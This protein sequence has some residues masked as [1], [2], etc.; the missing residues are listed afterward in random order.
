MKKILAFAILGALCLTLCGCLD[1]YTTKKN[2]SSLSNTSS[3][4]SKTE[5]TE[6]LK[7]EIEDL[8]EDNEECLMKIYS[9]LP[10]DYEYEDIDGYHLVNDDDYKTFED[11]KKFTESVYVND[12]AEELL[13]K[14]DYEGNP[15]YK[16]IGG[17]LYVNVKGFGGRGYNVDW[18]DAEIEILNV[19]ENECKFKV[20]AKS[21]EPGENVA[22]TP[23][24]V[25]SK[26]VMENGKWKLSEMIH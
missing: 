10:L 4:E 24:E 22:P 16:D 26:A 2:E 13:N 21:T 20:I 15:I 19:S 6:E 14:K 25:T 7:D 17:R 3:N 23:Y 9:V 5:I 18:D 12:V 11:L 8:V 1:K